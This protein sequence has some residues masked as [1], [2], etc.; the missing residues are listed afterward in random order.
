MSRA[1][2]DVPLR[3]GSSAESSTVIL[4]KFSSPMPTMIMD[5]GRAEAR[6]ISA[7]ASCMYVVLLPVVISP[8]VRIN[9]T[10]YLCSR[11]RW[12]PAAIAAASR[13]TGA[14]VVGADRRTEPTARR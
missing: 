12:N 8:S 13:I 9:K 4:V 6:T 5:I 11:S 1:A 14:K 7:M 10:K 2:T 3:S